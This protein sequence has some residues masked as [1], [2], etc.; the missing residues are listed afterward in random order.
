MHSS[1]VV[2]NTRLLSP[3][4]FLLV[5]LLVG[6]VLVLT[7]SSEDAFLPDGRKPDSVSIR[8][9]ELLLGMYPENQ[10]L[11]LTLI[12][13]LIRLG[14][15][16]RARRHVLKLS[17]GDSGNILFYKAELDV[18]EALANASGIESSAKLALVEHLRLIP[19]N[20]LSNDQLIRQATYALSLS[21]PDLGAPIYAELALRDPGQKIAWLGEAAKWYLASGDSLHAAN[22]YRELMEL[23][24]TSAQ[25]VDF[26][27]QAFFSLLASDRGEQAAELL[28]QHVAELSDADFAVLEAGVKAALGSRRFDLAEQFVRLWRLWQP[29]DTQAVAMEFQLHLAAGD[30]A[31][32]WEIGPLL[33]ESR[34]ND[35]ALLAEMGKLGEWTGHPRQALGYWIRLLQLSDDAVTHEHAWRLAAQLFD[36]DRAI[37]LLATLAEQRLLSDAELDALDYSHQSRGTPEQGELWLRG[38]L[39]DNPEH[40][41]AWLRLQ[42]ILAHTQQNAAEIQVWAEIDRRF[43]L[44]SSQ[45][46]SWAEAHWNLFDA[47]AAW[48]VLEV[49]DVSQV[50]DEA[51]WRLRAELAWELEQDTE[52]QQAY[53]RLLVLGLPLGSAGEDQLIAIYTKHAPEKALAIM[54]SSWQRRHAP[55][56]LASA[57]QLA[58]QLADWQQLQAL[59]DQASTLPQSKQA[60]ELWVA[61]GALEN[62]AGRV[63]EAEQF[64]LQGLRLFPQKNIFRER[65][66]WFYI[67]HNRRAEL[68]KLLQQWHNLA[69]TDSQLWLP[70]ASASLLVNRNEQALAW[71]RLYLDTNPLDWLVQSAYADALEN[72]GYFEK[73]LY[74]R[75]YLVKQVNPQQFG[76]DP[77]RYSTYLRLLSSSQSM[78]VAGRQAVLWQDGSVPMLQIWFDQFTAQ[79]GSNNQDALKSEWL[80]WARSNGLQ[81]SQYE[82]IQEALRTHNRIS[83]ERLLAAHTLDPAQRVEALTR[84]GRGAEALGEGLSGLSDEQPGIVRQQLLRQAV[85]LQERTPQGMQLGWQN[86]DF[87]GLDLQG[88]TAVIARQLDDDWYANLSLNQGRYDGDA[89][90]EKV[91]G[92]ENN[93]R[94]FLQRELS[95]GLFDVTLDSSLRDDQNRFGFGLSRRLQLSSRDELQI[96]LDWQQ[97]A[98]ETVFMR[99]LGMRDGLTLAGR[100]AFSARDQLNWSLGHRR[101]STRQGDALGRG[102]QLNLEFSHTLFFDGPTWVARSG[103]SYER[104]SLES[105]LPDNL[106]GGALRMDSVTP[107]DFLQERFGQLYLG[108][109]WR[110]GFP[111]AINRGRAQYTWLVDVLAGWQWTEQEFNYAIN[112]GVGMELLGDDELAFT[113]GYQSA[114][115]SGNGEAGGI[116]GV[117]YSARFGR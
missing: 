100:H 24:Q 6:S 11:R 17:D 18:L 70:F 68:P 57:L 109:T 81:I 13:Q 66:L 59:V 14:D 103:I 47:P 40:T 101:F 52:T 102:E 9:A 30:V 19:R 36:Y 2:K 31:R 58:E 108:S 25:R 99:A 87:G 56:R 92:R 41:R 46:V 113:F 83:L 12:E 1:S 65:L 62:R 43:G 49:V 22:I 69:S 84:L 106:L 97:E 104:N 50:K 53:E 74:L 26:L 85:E 78:P 5:I 86:R 98:E 27:E 82:Q 44:S 38:Y 60:P 15:Y 111:G 21:V 29:E 61:R 115:Q 72:A 77:A 89:L 91:L 45:R 55:Q 3:W 93:A 95:N 35:V 34:P 67:D 94:L 71:F 51:Y 20:N 8:Y 117:T 10:V 39:H 28:S 48:R 64:Y 79:L 16:S 4:A 105:D 33:V 23:A 63:S 116:L 112:L 75:S 7:Y 107:A 96:G 90:D 110:R 42:Q 80:A 114:P 73:A 37:P 76:L 32:A 88:P 54:V